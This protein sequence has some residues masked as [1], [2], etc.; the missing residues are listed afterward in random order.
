MRYLLRQKMFS[1]ADSFVIKND[2]EEPV[3]QVEGKVFSFGKK[4]SFQ[5]MASNELVFIQQRLL[6]WLPKYEILAGERVLAVVE[7]EWSFFKCRFL[8]VKFTISA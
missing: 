7:K 5:D 1:W 4:L 6:T 2:R 8:K 3:Y